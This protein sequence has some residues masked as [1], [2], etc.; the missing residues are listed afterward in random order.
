MEQELTISQAL[1]RRKNLKGDLA[2]Q[3]SRVNA[4]V[5]YDEKNQ[6]PFSFSE[7]DTAHREAKVELIELETAI[8]LANA[9]ASI[10]W[11]DATKPLAWVLRALAEI[12]GD[13]ARYEGYRH[14]G[15]QT[16]TR[17]EDKRMVS[18]TSQVLETPQ[19]SGVRRSH[20]TMEEVTVTISHITA[21]ECED[22]LQRLRDEFE[23]LNDKLETAN[24][25]TRITYKDQRSGDEEESQG[26]S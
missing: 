4:A 15:L 13:I 7:A 11:R 17:T 25:T 10:N 5:V 12:K 1:R 6:P 22:K 18:D 16:K 8:A 26:G 21:R 2:L 24:H 9:R 20:P 23:K 3:A 19:G 14:R